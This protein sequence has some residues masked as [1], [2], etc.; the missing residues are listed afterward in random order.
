VGASNEATW[1]RLTDT[2]GR[3]ELRDDSRFAD[4]AGRMRHLDELVDVLTRSFMARTTSEWIAQLGEAGVPVGPVASIGE[5]LEHPQTAAREMVVEVEHSRLGATRSLGSPVKLSG[6]QAAERPN[7]GA[8]LLGEH[9][10]AVLLE[11]GWSAE[12][13]DELA[14]AGSILAPGGLRAG[15]Y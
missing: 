14:G 13:I 6:M 10:R 1:T 9:T 15:P 4:N 12:E 2:L 11:Q 8:P 3:P 7:R 5:M